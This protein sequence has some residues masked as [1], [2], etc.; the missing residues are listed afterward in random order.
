MS[1]S[2]QYLEQDQE[3][4]YTRYDLLGVCA[5]LGYGCRQDLV[6]GKA[7]LERNKDSCYKSYGPGMMYAEGI[8]V[9]ENIEK[10]VEHL[11]AAGNYG[12]AWRR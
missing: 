10:G 6:W 3:P 11:K 7:L 9:R 8:G 12:P 4:E 1:E 2:F 5:L